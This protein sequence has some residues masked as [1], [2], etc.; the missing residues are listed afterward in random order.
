VVI[1]LQYVVEFYESTTLPP[2]EGELHELGASDEE[3]AAYIDASLN[4]AASLLSAMGLI[5]QLEAMRHS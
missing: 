2:K 4:M 5:F 3:I 1:D